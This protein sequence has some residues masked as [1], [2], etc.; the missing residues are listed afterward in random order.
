V[1]V[2]GV[3]STWAWIRYDRIKVAQAKIVELDAE[4]VIATARA[5]EVAKAEKEIANFEKLH[6]T[7]TG[8][9][10]R[11]MF[12][13]RTLDNFCNMLVQANDNQWSLPGYEVRC[14]NLSIAAAAAAPVAARGKAVGGVT[15]SF[16]TQFRIVGEE[17]DKAG[18]YLRSFFASVDRSRFWRDDGFLGRSEDTYKGDSPNWSSDTE[19]VITDLSFEW[20]RSKVLVGAKP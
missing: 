3:A 15:F 4:L 8:L 16:R 1:I 18:D 2:L 7:I 20:K 12:W 13:A 9:I 11:K 10:T 14:N 5:E 19:R 6:E 17:R